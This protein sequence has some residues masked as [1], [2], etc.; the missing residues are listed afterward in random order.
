RLMRQ[1]LTESILLALAGGLVGVAIAAWGTH[2]LLKLSAAQIP[3]S[4]EIGLDWRVFAFL[5]VVCVVTGVGFGLAH[6]IAAARADLQNGLK[7][8]SGR[9][10]AG[11]SHKRFRDGLGVAEVAMAF[12]LL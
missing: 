8:S 12:L 10:S 6:A 4:W 9:G 2:V 7:E 3:R 11:R 1:F 5:L